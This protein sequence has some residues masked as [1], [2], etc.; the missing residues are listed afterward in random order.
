MTMRPPRSGGTI[1]GTDKFKTVRQYIG[2]DGGTVKKQFVQRKGETKT[3]VIKRADLWQSQSAGTLPVPKLSIETGLEL[4]AKHQ[5]RRK[6]AD[7]TVKDFRL[8]AKWIGAKF[9]KLDVNTL[10]GPMVDLLTEEWMEAGKDAS[11]HK[12]LRWGKAAYNWII[13]NGWAK[14][15]PFKDAEPVEWEPD[16]WAEPMPAADFDKALAKVESPVMAALYLLLRWAGCRP[17]AARNLHRSE[18]YHDD[19]GRLMMMH[20]SKTK[21]SDKPQLILEPAASAILAL[22]VN[23]VFVFSLKDGKRVTQGTVCRTWKRACEAA[24]VTH[25]VPYDLR[26][27]RLSELASILDPKQLQYVA[28]HASV[29]TTYKHYV[30][31]DRE[32]LKKKLGGK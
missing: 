24:K 22:P 8:A 11:A 13:K 25:R 18:L 12:I 26:D 4:F 16:Q 28:G 15:N 23:S 5:E 10:T 17:D 7:S 32:N 27:M 9:G 19:E 20:R 21:N 3:A 6:R 2:P 1:K 30:K 14:S 29:T 31:V